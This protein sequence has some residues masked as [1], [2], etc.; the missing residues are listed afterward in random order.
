MKLR[1]LLASVTGLALSGAVFATPERTISL[2]VDN[3]QQSSGVL[4]F[5][6]YDSEQGLASRKP[7]SVFFKPVLASTD[8]SSQ[9]LQVTVPLSKSSSGEMAVMVFQD[10]DN[11][12]TMDKN[13]LG[14]PLEP[15]GFTN[16]PQKLGPPDW[17]D[18]KVNLTDEN[19]ALNITLKH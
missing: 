3:I 9:S 17:E 10:L 18:M 16:N 6:V 5:A 1:T 8:D 13:L 11:D 15:Y 12:Q 14:I 2:T 7:S 19:M 4:L